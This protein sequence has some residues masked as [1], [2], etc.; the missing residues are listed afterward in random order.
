MHRNSEA[1]ELVVN[2]PNPEDIPPSVEA[3]KRLLDDTKEEL[4]RPRELYLLHPPPTALMTM[5]VKSQTRLSGNG[6]LYSPVLSGLP[7]HENA[8]QT[9]SESRKLDIKANASE[10]I[11]N[12]QKWMLGSLKDA[13][14]TMRVSIGHLFLKSVHIKSLAEGFPYNAFAAMIGNPKLTSEFHDKYASQHRI[15]ILFV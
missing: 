6:K 11:T 4:E 14:L 15:S 10:I 2:A 9:W 1:R 8:L 3:I 7:L 13:A 5:E 12:I